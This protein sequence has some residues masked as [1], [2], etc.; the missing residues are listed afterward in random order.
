[1]IQIEKPLPPVE[2]NTM[3]LYCNQS[4]QMNSILVTHIWRINEKEGLDIPED[5]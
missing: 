1:V 2:D 5:T 4:A 3:D